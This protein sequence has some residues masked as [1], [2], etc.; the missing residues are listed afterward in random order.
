MKYTPKSIYD[1]LLAHYGD[2]GWWPGN[3]YEIMVGAVL[4]QNTAWGNVE[5]AL[6][7][8]G[9]RLA[10]EY[11]ESLPTP[12]LVDVIRPSGFYHA[13]A[14]CL[15]ALTA[16][17][18]GYGYNVETVQQ[19]PQPKI[20]SELLAIKGI[21][22]ETADAIL[23]YAFRYP[24]FVVDAYLKRLAQRLP[25]QTEQS[26]G[27]MQ[28]WFASGV[29]P[30]AQLFGTY[31]VLILEHGK[32]HCKKKPRCTGCPFAAGCGFANSQRQT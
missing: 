12:Q 15:Q 11:L 16:W 6:A 30:G 10:P 17:Y 31:H 29:A 18:K 28:A 20:R 5:Q 3:P 19:H 21:G 13:K 26:Y 7:N 32:T 25:V 23:L 8:F 27:K 22:Q 4:V 9:G 14:A 1:A 2:L 24:A